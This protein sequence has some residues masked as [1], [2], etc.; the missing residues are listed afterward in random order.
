M[1]IVNRRLCNRKRCEFTYKCVYSIQNDGNQNIAVQMNIE[2]HENDSAFYR[3][4]LRAL[5]TNGFRTPNKQ[6]SLD[7]ANVLIVELFR[8]KR[9]FILSCNW[10][11]YRS[12]FDKPRYLFRIPNEANNVTFSRWCVFI[13]SAYTFAWNECSDHLDMQ[14]AYSWYF[15]FHGLRAVRPMVFLSVIK[16]ERYL[17]KT[18]LK[19]STYWFW[20]WTSSFIL[21]RARHMT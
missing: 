15:I 20:T 21:L 19:L 8:L 14:I 6:L 18:S 13:L 12:V 7:G 10:W 17:K 4:N 5:R 9:N 1:I 3:C 16:K 11:Y 2:V